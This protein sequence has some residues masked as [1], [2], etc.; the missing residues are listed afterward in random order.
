MIVTWPLVVI[1]VDIWCQIFHE[2]EECS[3]ETFFISTPNNFKLCWWILKVL[4]FFRSSLKR[5][6]N[7]HMLLL[8][9]SLEAVFSFC[10][11][12]S[13]NQ[14]DFWLALFS[15]ALRKKLL[16]LSWLLD[17]VKL[18]YNWFAYNYQLLYHSTKSKYSYLAV[19]ITYFRS[20]LLKCI[21]K[22]TE[23]KL[24]CFAQRK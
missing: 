19:S 10:L 7:L 2:S 9:R 22:I 24:K 16:I 11:T 17:Y 23:Y 8:K 4:L 13:D 3:R 5:N 12:R 21:S 15:F 18:L 6:L 20:K 14:S 1:G